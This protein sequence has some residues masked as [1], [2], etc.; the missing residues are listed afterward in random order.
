MTGST[1]L[2]IIMS[3][4]HNPKMRGCAGHPIVQTP[5]LDVLAANG[6]T[7]DAAYC[8]SPVCIPARATFATGRFIHDI[9]FWDNAQPYDGSVPSWHHAARAAGHRA[10]SIGK[11]HFRSSEDD[12]GFSNSQIPMHVV[13]E[14]GDLMGLIREDLPVRGGAWKMAGMAGPGESMYSTYDRDITARAQIWLQ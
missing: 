14:L 7:F 13:E 3:D 10:D 5:N 6:T 4:E 11:L 2:L 8:N 1:N 12:N 9:E